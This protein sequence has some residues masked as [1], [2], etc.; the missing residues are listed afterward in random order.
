MQF[1]YLGGFMFQELIKA[2]LFIFIAEMGDK[3][4]ILAMAFATKYKVSQVLGGVFI[5]SLA[6]HALAVLVGSLLSN[7]IPINTIG[8]IAGISFIAFGIWT[9]KP[10]N[11]DDE[12]EN[13]NNFGPI[14]TVS[15]AFFV[16][17]L[18]DKTQ[19]TAL[20]LATDSAYPAFILT[21][22]VLGMIVTSGFGIFIGSKLG[23]KVPEF[24]I[25]IVSAIVFI[26]FGILKVIGTAPLRYK[27]LLNGII[28][29]GILFTILAYLLRR[30]VQ[31]KRMGRVTA[32]KEISIELYKKYHDF[33]SAV[34]EI[35]L[36]E[37]YCGS[38]K[39][40]ECLIG[41][42]KRALLYA[43]ANQKIILPSEWD[44]IPCIEDKDFNEDKVIYALSLMLAHLSDYNDFKEKNYVI[45]KTKEVLETV[46]FGEMI[47]V[48]KN[49]NE[50]YNKIYKKDN[51]IAEKI[52]IKV[53]EIKKS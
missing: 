2:F 35:C 26:F 7:V 45:R 51:I 30:N 43:D 39:G 34:D 29:F 48:C 36:S 42:T 41:Y 15:I 9:L 25:K 5:G 47:P 38:C 52:K 22:T 14:L 12:E 3:T 31:L 53:N 33:K 6:N 40:K 37:E 10:D 49:I 13:K 1:S 4:Q 18:G 21:G 11:D 8:L 44:D 46:L 28:F 27:T 32:F 20:T 24:T 50:Y 16:G 17:E 19:L 23:E